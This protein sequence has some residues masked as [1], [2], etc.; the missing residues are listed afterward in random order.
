MN[1]GEKLNKKGDKIHFFYDLG[2]RP[3]QR[4]STGIYLCQTQWNSS[5]VDTA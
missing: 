5:F 4:P 2:R 1:I 3:R